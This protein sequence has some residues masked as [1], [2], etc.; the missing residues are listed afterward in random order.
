MYIYHHS[1][2]KRA[3]NPNIRLDCN[4]RLTKSS[5]ASKCQ[6]KVG[7]C[8]FHLLLKVCSLIAWKSS[9][10][11]PDATV[12]RWKIRISWKSGHARMLIRST[13]RCC[14]KNGDLWG[15]GDAFRLKVRLR[16]ALEMASAILNKI[17]ILC[18][19]SST[20]IDALWQMFWACS[21]GPRALLKNC[22]RTL[23]W[24]LCSDYREFGSLKDLRVAIETAWDNI[25]TNF[26][27]GLQIHYL[28]DVFWLSEKDGGYSLLSC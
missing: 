11:K 21:T 7:A 10:T 15:S 23:C 6:S 28:N 3:I 20:P 14:R 12:A 24:A 8:Y 9:W 17:V 19:H 27:K 5:R 25:D 16:N 2:C 4:L 13:F 22:S 26:L 18:V 1:V